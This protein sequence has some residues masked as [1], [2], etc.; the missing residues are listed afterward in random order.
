MPQR[1]ALTSDCW[2]ALNG[3]HYIVVTA[4]F[5]DS[6]W[7]LNKKIID[8]K[9]FPF[10]HNGSNLS[11]TIMKVVREFRLEFKIFFISVNNVTYTTKIKKNFHSKSV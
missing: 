2:E 4:H 11:Q 10:P 8:F 7:L 6:Y 5:I 1:V 9:K 3:F